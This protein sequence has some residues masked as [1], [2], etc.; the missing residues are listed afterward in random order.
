MSNE[1][2]TSL[3]FLFCKENVS[4]VFTI[5]PDPFIVNCYKHFLILYILSCA[6][7]LHTEFG[8]IIGSIGLLWTGTVSLI[9]TPFHYSMHW[10]L[11]NHAWQSLYIGIVRL[12]QDLQVFNSRGQ[13]TWGQQNYHWQNTSFLAENVRHTQN[14]HHVIGLPNVLLLWV[15][16]NSKYMI[17]VQAWS[18]PLSSVF[19]LFDCVGYWNY[20]GDILYFIWNV[21]QSITY[22][23]KYEYM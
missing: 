11:T 5:L 7:W 8:F 23:L 13:N 6:I 4:S 16:F 17:N 19:I 18:F 22:L 21:S 3:L 9:Y 2:L 12:K 14:I 1:W 15:K 10:V 20:S